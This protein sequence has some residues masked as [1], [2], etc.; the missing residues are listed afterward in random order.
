MTKFKLTEL[1]YLERRLKGETREYIATECGIAL[2]TLNYHLERWG[3]LKEQEEQSVLEHMRKRRGTDGVTSS[4]TQTPVRSAVQTTDPV[5]DALSKDIQIRTRESAKTMAASA[6]MTD[7]AQSEY[8]T[9]KEYEWVYPS[10]S[11]SVGPMTVNQDGI[12]MSGDV[13]KH[14]GN[15][16]FVEVGFKHGVVILRPV[17]NT[18]AWRLKRDKV[19]NSVVVG[20]ARL[21]HV[22][23]KHGMPKGTALE[24]EWLAAEC[25]M[26]CLVQ[27]AAQ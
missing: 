21:T 2:A 25:V 24:P 13:A 7:D 19:T 8:G 15:Y 11:R 5:N 14:F 22:A 18:R 4:S 17:P 3:I 9:T 12:R 10:T 1:L 20:S 6:P 23:A 27:G 26:K 16:Q